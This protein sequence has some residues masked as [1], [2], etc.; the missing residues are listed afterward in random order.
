MRELN[1][2]EPI[3]AVLTPGKLDSQAALSDSSVSVLRNA[4]EPSPHEAGKSLTAFRGYKPKY[5]PFVSILSI[6][7]THRLR[8]ERPFS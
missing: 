2:Y 1:D 7:T 8:Q 4:A 5:F 3:T 6:M